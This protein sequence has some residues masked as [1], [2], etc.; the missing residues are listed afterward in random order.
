MDVDT[1]RNI[2]R[3]KDT[4]I[5]DIG[6]PYLSWRG[7]PLTDRDVTF[8][9]APDVYGHVPQEMH[10]PLVAA[11]LDHA[12]I[13]PQRH[14]FSKEPYLQRYKGRGWTLHAPAFEKHSKDTAEDG[15]DQTFFPTQLKLHRAEDSYDSLEAV[16]I[17]H[18][19]ATAARLYNDRMRGWRSNTNALAYARAIGIPVV[20]RPEMGERRYLDPQACGQVVDSLEQESRMLVKEETG[21]V[22][23]GY[24]RSDDDLYPPAAAVRSIYD[25]FRQVT[26]V[27]QADLDE[28]LMDSLKTQFTHQ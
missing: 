11:I 10:L 28:I 4:S 18:H 5:A 6:K 20:G 9:V 26:G 3:L 21:R 2:T 14:E 16:V 25:H 23:P 15:F 24:K 8:H 22:P 13:D 7:D 17:I 19:N 12:G 1:L 27:M